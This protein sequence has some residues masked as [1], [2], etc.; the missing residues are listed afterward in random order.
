MIYID[1]SRVSPPRSLIER[2]EKE[3]A[4][5]VAFYAD[6]ENKDQRFDFK[7]YRSRG[8]KQA[9]LSLFRDKCA[10]CESRIEV[11]ATMNYEHF[12]PKAMAVNLNGS[13][14]KPGYWWLASEWSNLYA[15][16]QACNRTKGMRFP[17]VGQRARFESGPD[18]SEEKALLLDPCLDHPVNYLI[19]NQNGLVASAPPDSKTLMK[20]DGRRF[21]GHDRGQITIDIYGLNRAELVRARKRVAKDTMERLQRIHDGPVFTAPPWEKVAP[22]LDELLDVNQPYVALRRQLVASWSE[23]SLYRDSLP[24]ECEPY[25]I[26]KD[27]EQHAFEQ[28][29]E[30]TKRRR[31]FS[32][33]DKDDTDVYVRTSKIAR[34]EIE[35]FRVIGRLVAF[36]FGSDT[37]DL[38]GWK[39]LLGE[40]GVGKSSVLQAVSLALMGKKHFD[41]LVDALKDFD[42]STLLKRGESQGYVKVYL[43]ADPEPV[44]VRLTKTG[45]EFT[46]PEA[47]LRTI[48]LGFGSARWLPRLGSAAPETQPFIR[49]LNLYNPFVPLVDA[50][51]WLRNLSRGEFRKTEEVLLRL[52]QL[53]KGT[54]LRR[55]WDKK[56]GKRMILVQRPGQPVTQA[57]PLDEFSDGYQTVLA[58]AVTIMKLTDKGMG[59]RWDDVVAAEGLVLLDEIGAHLHPQWKMHIVSSLRRAFP[60]MQFLATTHEPLCLRGLYDDEVVVMQRSANGQI[61]AITELPPVAG[62]RVDQLLTSEYFGLHSTLDT[63]TDKKFKKYYRL[64]ALPERS[65]DQQ[66]Q[67]AKLKDQLEELDLMGETRR[68]R[69]MLGA[70]DQA[71]ASEADLDLD[72]V[73]H[74]ED[75]TRRAMREIWSQ[76]EGQEES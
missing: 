57:L 20:L 49:V 70:I 72:K 14:T 62:L 74:L 53:E 67:L 29:E 69:L 34:V 55:R 39:V 16:C 11:T 75:E 5:T 42:P 43:A 63:E 59:G 18:V 10:F 73:G 76:L 17:V 41:A 61:T 56:R 32:V 40:N 35:N 6:P 54:R 71:L 23:D 33:E 38:A 7:V 9:L 64:L 2:G 4:R 8:V 3:L 12:R 27:V 58:M 26:S 28:F 22:Q 68:Q 1:R 44:E 24:S 66:A 60:N 31:T 13:I 48:L 46:N 52:L 50:L 25:K 36:N 47:G 21:R 30:T 19:F 51:A 37:A 15:S 65:D 45:V